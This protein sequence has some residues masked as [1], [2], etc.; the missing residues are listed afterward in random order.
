MNRNTIAI[1]TGLAALVLSW[2]FP[3]W[4]NTYRWDG[5]FV[6]EAAIGPR[7]LFG[8]LPQPPGR[9]S[10]EASYTYRVDSGRLMLIDLCIAAMTV[11]VILVLKRP[12]PKP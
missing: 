10:I 2:L 7:F 11:G 1:L 6:E 3:P 8:K 12:K 5:K 9:H 4:I